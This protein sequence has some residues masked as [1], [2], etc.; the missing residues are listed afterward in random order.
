ML[1][2]TFAA[3]LAATSADLVPGKFCRAATSVAPTMQCVETGRGA[4]LANSAERAQE[5]AHYALAGEA[6]FKTHFGAEAPFHALIDFDGK[7]GTGELQKALVRIGF[8]R[9]LPWLSREAY[10]H[11]LRG[12]TRQM[13]DAMAGARNLRPAEKQ[14]LLD[15]ELR[16]A[17]QGLSRYEMDLFET[18]VVPHE[19]GHGWYTEML[20][21]GFVMDK[22]GHYGSPS[23]DWLDETAAILM[24]SGDSAEV[25][26]FHFLEAY[27]GRDAKR[28]AGELLDLKQFLERDHP[29]K[30]NN[31][32]ARATGS[33][34]EEMTV[35]VKYADAGQG[36]HSGE[37]YYEQARVFA[38]FLIDRTGDRAIFAPIGRAFAAGR[39]MNDW[40]ASNGSAKNLPGNIEGLQRQ[41]HAWLKARFGAP[42]TRRR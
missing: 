31:Q 12:A 33:S 6:R 10:G 23:P 8:R 9:T 21:P 25:R 36:S 34:K 7:S 40:L 32:T 19:I 42:V 39:S 28:H 37:R 17:E 35:T 27:V 1:S 24:E 13:V 20:W 3:A 38:D 16:K 5:L 14:A 18:T 11:A 26:R 30:E 2:M 4:A 29:E 15:E 41:W 22:M